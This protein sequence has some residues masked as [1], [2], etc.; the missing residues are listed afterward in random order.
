MQIPC[1]SEMQIRS[2]FDDVP[3]IDR[4][5]WWHPLKHLDKFVQHI[6]IKLLSNAMARTLPQPTFNL[7][8]NS[9]IY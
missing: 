8:M 1:H 9:L 5:Y 7:G 4:D 6:F 2:S 3:H